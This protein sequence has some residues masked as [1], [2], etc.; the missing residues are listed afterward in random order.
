MT[1][2]PKGGEYA[3]C[4]SASSC[5]CTII[6][7]HSKVLCFTTEG[8]GKNHKWLVMVDRQI[9]TVSTTQYNP[10]QVLDVEGMVDANPNG[11]E[12]VVIRG[13]DFGHSQ[14]KLEYVT[15]GP[16]GTEYAASACSL[17]SHYEIRCKTSEGVGKD[18]RWLLAVDG[19]VSTLSDAT[20]NY[21]SP[22]VFSIT[23]SDGMTKG[24]STHEI[25]G[26]NLASRVAGTYIELRLD[27]EPFSLDGLGSEDGLIP[28]TMKGPSGSGF[29]SYKNDTH[30][31]IVFQLPEMI[32]LHQKKVLS[33]KVG[34]STKPNVEQFSNSLE[35]NY[36]PPI[37]DTIENVEGDPTGATLSVMT[38][39]LV[40]RGANFAGLGLHE[41]DVAKIYVNGV[42]QTTWSWDHEKITLNYLGMK[43]SVQVQVGDLWSNKMNF[44][45]SSPELLWETDYLPHTDG[46]KTTGKSQ[47]LGH[48]NLT[49][50]GCFF[51]SAVSNLKITVGDVDCPIYPRSLKVIPSREDFCLT[52]TLREVT[53]KV[54]E[55]TGDVNTVVL[56]RSG[57]P[58]FS[59]NDGEFEV[60]L[61]YL[62]PI[63]TSFIPRV[64]DTAGGE[65]VIAGENFG[66][67]PNL[68]S[69]M[70]GNTKL[71]V[72]D[73]G[74]PASEGEGTR[75]LEEGAFSH[76][77]ITVRVPPGEGLPKDVV[78]D[79]DGQTFTVSKDDDDFVLKYYAPVVNSLGPNTIGTQGGQVQAK[80]VYL[81]REG[82]ANAYM[83][84]ASGKLDWIDVNIIAGE[85]TFLNISVGEGQGLTDI[86]LNVSHNEA[87]YQLH[88]LPP[89]LNEIE[90]GML[91]GTE[92]GEHIIIRGQNFGVG[93]DFAITIEDTNFGPDDEDLNK[94]LFPMTYDENHP[95]V[96]E[97]NHTFLKLLSPEGENKR[98]MPLTLS[99]VVAGQ[100]SNGIVV[101]YEPPQIDKMVMCFP[102]Q[103]TSVHPHACVGE[104]NPLGSDC[105][106]YA[107]G[108]CGLTTDGRYTLAIIGENFGNPA[109]GAQSV[110]FGDQELVDAEDILFVSH[111]EI[112]L[113][114]PPG[115]G[116]D[117]PITLKVGERVANEMMFSYDP[118]YVEDVS[119]QRPDANGDFITIHGVN[120]APT[121]ELAGD[122]R[123]Y[124]GQTV[125]GAEPD[126]EEE[127]EG[128]GAT[129]RFLEGGALERAINRTEWLPCGNPTF[130]DV[131]FP[132]WQ[133]RGS[134]NPY[135]WCETPRVTVGAKH[136]K[137]SV[138]GQNVT[139]DRKMELIRPYCLEGTYGQ[140]Q[141]AVY[142]GVDRSIRENR[143]VNEEI[144]GI[145][146]CK[147]KCKKE[148][149]RCSKAWDDFSRTI[150]DETCVG[151]HFCDEYE[152]IAG[153]YHNC[154]VLTRED[155]YCADCPGGASCTLNTQ[156][157]EE[158]SAMEG[159]WRHELPASEENCAES[160]EDRSH[161]AKCYDVVPC[162]PFEACVGDNVCG[163][164]Y[165][166]RKCDFCCDA[167]HSYI[168]DPETGQEIPNPECWRA[169]GERIKYF[170]K[171]GVCAPCPSNPWMIVAILLGG[172]TFGGMTAY[173]MKKKNINMGICSIGVDYLQILALLSSTKTPW[174]QIVLDIYTWLSA[175][176]F[177]INITAPECVFEIAYDDKWKMIMM[178][179][180][181]LWCVVLVYNKIIWFYKKFIGR[182]NRK[183]R[184]SH[185][186][187]T[188]GACIAIMYYIYLNLSMTALEVF[189]CSTQELEDP[190]TG[191]IV[192]DGKEY[193][194]E[195]NWECY[196]SD[197]KQME[198]LPYAVVAIAVY[199]IGYPCFVASILLNRHN[200]AMA[201][202][203]QVLRAQ[204][205]GNTKGT[206]PNCWEFR[207][208]YYKLYYYYKPSHWY[209]MLV[210]FGRKFAIAVIA[211][212]FRANATF[213]MCMVVLTIFVSSNIQV[214]AQP[215]MSMSERASVIKEFK[216]VSN[217]VND[218]INEKK[219]I[220]ANRILTGVKSD[221]Y[222]D[223][224][225]TGEDV[226]AYFWN[227]NTVEM[228]L[229]GCSILI[230]I[231][232]LMFESKYLKEKSFEYET[233][234]RCGGKRNLW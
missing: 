185:S 76:D 151:V 177:N 94:L 168:T 152:D 202:E 180:V 6:E 156:Y 109:N 228:I 45:D 46:Y 50:A 209:W 57:N 21:A 90:G 80:G 130:G 27:G 139:I 19:Q 172:A 44:S 75:R 1:Y 2:G 100:K 215:Y 20:T 229:L 74:Q 117:I 134:S 68:V 126:E 59:G 84:D 192:S 5:N 145:G 210:I 23:S 112:H 61:K 4:S 149:R 39:D 224:E 137:V 87:P 38:S 51:Q 223:M 211:L 43:G 133:Q 47:T 121:L 107:E 63:V 144:S 225:M 91:F 233:F 33:V 71:E 227:Y 198:L 162:A 99:L 197:S 54:P 95:S 203:D 212:L 171:Y 66:N 164:G 36:L 191:E 65:V 221:A 101:D 124:I 123:I 169:D 157:A 184:H 178:V 119:P 219:G 138:A 60:K 62:P 163:Y 32:K 105:D 182:K 111:K 122:I 207:C 141:D 161:R 194:Q 42:E 175:F 195:T 204:D 208:R 40:I 97:F 131:A 18:L 96:L 129:R 92:G 12:D 11:Q 78:V 140:E 200:A 3:P 181:G 77:K 104:M 79:V 160:W 173:I 214:R 136:M 73:K 110:F 28:P 52:D 72:L 13:L 217:I 53:C 29:T 85:Q 98:N 142:E 234:R 41:A 196:T 16:S 189:N 148:S 216:E 86:V 218:L 187:K 146:M 199:T 10:P 230:N 176:N 188:V 222:K 37:I 213:Q 205:L 179:P 35:F 108:G 67:D 186:D 190:L 170:R 226:A 25:I 7:D 34:H 26:K 31:S 150:T 166:G 206:N 231:F 81:G 14:D 125:Y 147:A 9:S 106:K 103:L 55:G 193:M 128:E 132:I 116:L 70:M 232:G 64:V 118:P 30:E 201:R 93:K 174:P 89:S 58:N 8:T 69:V 115:V 15:Y 22:Q 113:R 56:L 167:M 48:R 114:V 102:D 135:L 155:E 83:K 88:Y 183:K 82:S 220:G 49:L 158:P 143:N 24:L 154:T 127:G 165:T 17:V 120:F 159:Y 153:D